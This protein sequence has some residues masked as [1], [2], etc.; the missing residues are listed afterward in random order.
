MINHFWLDGLQLSWKMVF[1]MNFFYILPAFMNFCCHFVSI[2][3]NVFFIQKYV[4]N[5]IKVML[6]FYIETNLISWNEMLL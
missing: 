5:L 1:S 3:T 4:L 6:V 2:A